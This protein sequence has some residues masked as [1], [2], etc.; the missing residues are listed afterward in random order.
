MDLQLRNKIFLVGGATSGFGNAVARKLLE[1]GAKVIAVARTAE[2]LSEFKAEYPDQIEAINGD[3]TDHEIIREIVDFIG[4]RPLEGM[5]VNAGG[6]PAKA[7]LETTMEDW[8]TAW[9]TVMRWK[10]ELILKLLPKFRGQ[11]YGRIVLLESI[12]VKQ[13]VENLVLSNAMRMGVVGFAKTLSQEI[14]KEGVTINIMAPGYHDT[15]AVKRVLRKKSE[16]SGKSYEE[17]QKELEKKIPVGR[18]GTPEEFASLAVWL[19]SPH[20][21]YI[22]GQTISV[23]GGIM[24]G[25]FG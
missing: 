25:S 6:P 4:D 20:S 22:T 12:S 5:L 18:M 17:V 1:E 13:P 10:I 7:T 9:F 8:D 16:V 11:Q 14:S 3:I 24:G 2:K 23:D 21:S 15:D 19:L